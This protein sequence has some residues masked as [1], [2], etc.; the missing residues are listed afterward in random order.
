MSQIQPPNN[1]IN[2]SPPIF[3]Q[4]SDNFQNNQEEKLE[5]KLQSRQEQ[6]SNEENFSQIK[7]S[8][9]KQE[10]SLGE[11]NLN[12]IF[13]QKRLNKITNN[14][15][16]ISLFNVLKIPKNIYIQLT[17]EEINL[18]DFTKII[19]LFQ[20]KNIDDKFKGLIGLRKLLSLEPNSPIQEII[21]LKLVPEL[22]S[23]LDNSLYEFIYEATY[24]LC[25][26]ASGTEEQ[27]NTIL[28][29]GGIPSMKKILALVLSL[30]LLISCG[31]VLAEEE[32]GPAADEQIG[33]YQLFNRTGEGIVSIMIKD[34]KTDQ[35][36]AYEAP[37]DSP[38]APDDFVELQLSIP[39]G[40]DPE[41]RLTLTFTT[42]TGK[43]GE[44]T[45]LSIESVAIDLLDVDAVAGATP[46]KFGPAP[47]GAVV[48]E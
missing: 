26:I 4:K 9:M 13:L 40:E 42:D 3:L 47:E 37:V 1:N 15:N 19:N 25:N 6:F 31:A 45:T 28:I 44:F 12:K 18:R 14:E 8:A 27:A 36:A 30:A 10:L 5:N 48:V 7:E 2:S 34:N 20:S 33:F 39:A 32:A 24:C 35:F 29:Y 46:I 11:N 16:N 41:H 17:N 21:E 23:L 43:T 38:L 22:I